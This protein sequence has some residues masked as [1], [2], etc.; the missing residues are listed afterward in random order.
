MCGVSRFAVIIHLVGCELAEERER[1]PAW[2]QKR[3][4]GPWIFFIKQ[5][6]IMG[7][8]GR[9]AGVLLLLWKP[10]SKNPLCSFSGGAFLLVFLRTQNP[11]EHTGRAERREFRDGRWEWEVGGFRFFFSGRFS[12]FQFPGRNSMANLFLFGGFFI[13]RA[14][15]RP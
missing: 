10:K 2:R 14:I 1:N 8:R 5:L 7:V 9:G 11:E 4:S 6:R 13:N 3:R 15:W 12:I